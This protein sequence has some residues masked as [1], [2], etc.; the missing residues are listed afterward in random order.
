MKAIIPLMAL[1]LLAS[2]RAVLSDDAT[3]FQFQALQRQLAVQNQMQIDAQIAA[4]QSAARAASAAQT[5]QMQ[6]NTDRIFQERLMR[7]ALSR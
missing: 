6:Q 1:A 7:E 3:Y 5:Y 4:Q 2:S